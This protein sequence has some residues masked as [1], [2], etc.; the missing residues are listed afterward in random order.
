MSS[1]PSEWKENLRSQ[2]HAR[3]EAVEAF[4]AHQLANLTD[5]RARQM[6]QSL[7]TVEQ[8]RERPD[9][10]GLVE[11]QATFSQPRHD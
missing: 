10:P 8:W 7:G 6:I 9:W 1:D 2:Y 11:R 3:S 4:K 5:E